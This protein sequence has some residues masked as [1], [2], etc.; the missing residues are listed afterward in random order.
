M[1]L[2]DVATLQGNVF[3]NP[4]PSGVD[5]ADKDA[6]SYS[7]GSFQLWLA[8]AT[9]GSTFGLAMLAWLLMQ[10]FGPKDMRMGLYSNLV[11]C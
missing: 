10:C 8:I 2:T 11:R 7:P 6:E 4:I 5:A 9:F 3:G 1:K